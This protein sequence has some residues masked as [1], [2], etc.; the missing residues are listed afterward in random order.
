[1]PFCV[2]SNGRPEK[3]S[4]T[5]AASGLA[6][7]FG[8]RVFTAADVS[9]GKPAPDI[10]LLAAAEMGVSARR[11]IVVED[12]D[13]GVAAARAARMTVVRYVASGAEPLTGEDQV[14]RRMAE[15]PALLHLPRWLS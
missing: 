12:S 4:M 1:M 10:F 9:R 8:D 15:L 3:V 13:A 2:A 7:Y 6:S 14:F 5:L 11:C